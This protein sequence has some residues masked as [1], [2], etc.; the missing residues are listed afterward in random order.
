MADVPENL[1]EILEVADKVSS[2]APMLKIY[3]DM[4]CLEQSC[5][6]EELKLAVV[7]RRADGSGRIGPSWEGKEFL[8]DLTKLRGL[9]NVAE[10]SLLTPWDEVRTKA[11]TSVGRA[12]DIIFEEID[13]AGMAGKFDAI[14]AY[15]ESIPIVEHPGDMSLWVGVL[16]ITRSLSKSLKKRAAFYE[17]VKQEA[18]KRGRDVKGLLGGLE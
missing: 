16:S 2:F 5:Q 1:S 12:I 6:L 18:L 3:M 8:D 10:G 7:H 17:A 14:D 11:E 15:I 9:L 4:L 13:D